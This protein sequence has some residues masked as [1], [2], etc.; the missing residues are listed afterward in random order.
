MRLVT[1]RRQSVRSMRA[2]AARRAG[3][4]LGWVGL[5]LAAL[6]GTALLA[7]GCGGGS[8]GQS[9]ASLGKTTTASRASIAQPVTRA[10]VFNRAI[11]FSRCMRAHGEPNFPDPV[12]KGNS[13]SQTINPSSGVDPNSP[14]FAAA[15]GACE[16]LLPN[17]G[18]PLPSQRET[19][20]PAEQADYLAAGACMRKRGVPDFPDPTFLN[21]TVTFHARAAID[22]D[23]AQYKRALATCQELIPAGLPYSKGST[24]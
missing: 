24:P 12:R 8:S 21:G 11:S 3:G 23:S 17:N 19:I 2:T 22:T 13:L 14:P 1:Q 7:A 4:C 5:A 18:A 10:S 20:T 16:H 6:I 15:R 9:V